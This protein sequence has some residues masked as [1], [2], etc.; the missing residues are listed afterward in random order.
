MD[1]IYHLS[2]PVSTLIICSIIALESEKKRHLSKSLDPPL[3]AVG[4]RGVNGNRV[5]ELEY[6]AVGKRGVSGYGCYIAT[7]HYNG[8]TM[9]ITPLL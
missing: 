2:Q 3:S 1:C 8:I 9:Y 4:R 6:S 7:Y 5:I